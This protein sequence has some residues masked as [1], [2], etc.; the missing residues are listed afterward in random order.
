MS[1]V[2]D[3]YAESNV[4]YDAWASGY[5]RGQTFKLSSCY[6][7]TQCSFWIKRSTDEITG[8]P[9]VRAKLYHAGGTFGSS[10]KPS[11]SALAVSGSKAFSTISTTYAWVTFTFATPYT[12]EADLPYGIAIEIDDDS[13][14]DIITGI[15]NTSPTHSGNYFG[16]TEGE[17]FSA[18]SGRDLIF[19]VSGEASTLALLSSYPESNYETY[20]NTQGYSRGQTFTSPATAY[21][22]KRCTFWIRRSSNTITGTPYLRAK[23]YAHSGTFGSSGV[24]TGSALATSSNVLQSGLSSEELGWVEFAFSTPYTLSSSTNYCIAV[25]VDSDDTGG[26]YVGYDNDSP[27]HS[28][29]YFDNTGGGW[30]YSTSRD[31]IFRVIGEQAAQNASVTA[32]AGTVA[33]E[34]AAP[35]VAAGSNVSVSVLSGAAAFESTVPLVAAVRNVSISALPGADAFESAAPLVAA[36]KNVSASV[37]SGAA[38]FESVAPLVTAVR[39]VSVPVLSGAAAFES[40]APLVTAVRNVSVSVLSGAAAF[41]SVAPLVTAVRNVSVSA[42]SG[43]VSFESAALFVFSNNDAFI[44]AASGEIVLTGALLIAALQQSA[45][46]VSTTGEIIFVCSVPYIE[47]YRPITPCVL[48]ELLISGANVP[49]TVVQSISLAVSLQETAFEEVIIQSVNF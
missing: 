45:A 6:S 47:S 44:L 13:T 29:N 48:T 36:T 35:V 40:V 22:L 10:S 49:L 46:I 31:I 15:D 39:N 9:S 24:P 11:G 32:P 28:G 12:V 37:L 43:A 17:G 21:N 4:S 34:S 38:A 30:S 25:E 3:S 20:S 19:K 26:L 1:T 18:E 5:T 7:L 27:M 42:L 2:L 16:G 33:F 41:E 14:A 23:L 8:T